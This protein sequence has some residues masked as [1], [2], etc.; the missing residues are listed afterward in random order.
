[1]FVPGCTW[2]IM[3][4]L[5]GIARVKACLIGWPRFVLCNRRIRRSA[6]SA[7][8][9]LRIAGRVHRIAIVCINHMARRTA[10]RPVIS[11]MIVCSR[12]GKHRIKQ[13]RLLQSQK[14][15][16]G[17]QFRAKSA[18]TQLVVWLSRLFF[19]R[20]ISDLTPSCGL[21][22]QIRAA[23]FRAAKFPNDTAALTPE[24]FLSYASSSAVGAG[25]VFS[26]CGIPSRS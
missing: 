2:Q 24:G 22:V 18:V 10:A 1:M 3:H 6:E 16:I 17:P 15:R 26:A 5:E 12:Q 8:T 21:L 20:R 9:V 25:I 14:N 4:W 13:P 7:V 11:R 23:H 19:S